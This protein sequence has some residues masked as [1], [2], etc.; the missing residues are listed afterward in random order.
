MYD[1][2]GSHLDGGI[3]DDKDWQDYWKTVTVL[4]SQWYDVPPGT[5]GRCF[6]F[7]LGELSEGIAD[8]QWILGQ[9][10]I[11]VGVIL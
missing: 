7:I 1:N 3:T 2:D 6:L 4:P 5:V 9:F 10:I 8:L 11:F